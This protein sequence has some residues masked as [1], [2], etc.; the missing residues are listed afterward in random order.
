MPVF[1]FSAFDSLM[2]SSKFPWNHVLEII[3]LPHTYSTGAYHGCVKENFW[4]GWLVQKSSVLSRVFAWEIIWFPTWSC[5]EFRDH[6][7]DSSSDWWPGVDPVQSLRQST[8]QNRSTATPES[9]LQSTKHT[10]S[11]N[12]GNL[13]PTIYKIGGSWCSCYNVYFKRPNHF[14]WHLWWWVPVQSC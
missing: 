5:E 11:K 1:H 3:D 12:W 9:L 6:P 8:H 7:E 14:K 10:Q 4:I 2:Q 13:I